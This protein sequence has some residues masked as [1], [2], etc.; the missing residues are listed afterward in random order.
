MFRDQVGV[1]PKLYAR[2]IRFNRVMQH[3][4]HGGHGTWADL[5]LEFGYYDQAHL[6]RDVR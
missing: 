1:A 4:R 5:A 6:V 3:L 2:I